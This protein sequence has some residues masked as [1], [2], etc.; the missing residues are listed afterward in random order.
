V[1]PEISAPGTRSAGREPA[2]DI[3]FE[4]KGRDRRSLLVNAP[5]D[6]TRR[7]AVIVLHGGMG[8]GELMRDDSG[9]DA[10]ARAEGFMV[11]YAEA[12][13]FGAERHAWNTGFLLRRHVQDADDIASFDALIDLLVR[14]TGPTRSGC[15]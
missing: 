7:P 12:T 9:F 8:S 6:G 2:V 15:P 4:V 5:S 10:V 1:T 11:A 3:S 13:S 14:S